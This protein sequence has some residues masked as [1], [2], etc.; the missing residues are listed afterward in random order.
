MLRVVSH[1][2]LVHCA[3]EVVL[4]IHYLFTQYLFPWKT[5]PSPPS[6]DVNTTTPV[7]PP[8]PRS[9]H[10]P[11]TIRMPHLFVSSDLF[12]DEDLTLASHPET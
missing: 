1:L 9:R 12:R 4:N 8:H 11:M 6:S 5:N 7:P 2:S 3:L 10:T